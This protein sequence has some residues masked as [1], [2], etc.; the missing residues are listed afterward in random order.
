MDGPQICRAGTADDLRDRG[1]VQRRLPRARRRRV[2]ISQARL[3]PTA[4][5]L[6]SLAA[7]GVALA[8][9]VVDPFAH[10]AWLVAYL[11]LVGFVAQLLLGFGQAALSTGC[12]APARRVWLRQ[13]FLWN[14]GVVAV[15]VG[16]LAQTRLAVIAGSLSL[17]VA[18][19]SLTRNAGPGLAESIAHRRWRGWGYAALLAAMAVST[20]IGTALAWDIPWT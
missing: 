17:I 20:L 16:V 18:L 1:I 19:A 13:A 12:A 3:E 14:L 7:A 10:G 5:A 9:R 11:V 6:A 4:A 2:I 15:P 8:V